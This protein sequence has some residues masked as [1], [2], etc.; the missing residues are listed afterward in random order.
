MKLSKQMIK[1]L[2]YRLRQ[3]RAGQADRKMKKGAMSA[4]GT[5]LD[6]YYSPDK[7][8]PDFMTEDELLQVQEAM[9]SEQK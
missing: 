1:H 3:Y 5:Y 8:L 2:A 4:N 9:T 6:G 7:R